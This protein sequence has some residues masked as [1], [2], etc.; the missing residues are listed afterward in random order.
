M[1]TYICK[2]KNYFG[3]NEGEF[4]AHCNVHKNSFTHC[5]DEKATKLS[6]TFGT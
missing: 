1:K 5:I 4:K 2:T 6:N 3:T